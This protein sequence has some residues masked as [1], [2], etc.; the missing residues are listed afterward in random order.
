MNGANVEHGSREVIEGKLLAVL[1]NPDKVAIVATK[2]DLELLITGLDH[3][4]RKRSSVRVRELMLGIMKLR[5]EA[6]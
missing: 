6:F 1:A 4:P 3:H 5:D 2:E